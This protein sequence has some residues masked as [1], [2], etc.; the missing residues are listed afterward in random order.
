MAFSIFTAAILLFQYDREK[1]YRAGQ[2]EITLDNITTF[3][4]HFIEQNE[5]ITRNQINKIDSI[6]SL[7]PITNERL[8]VIDNTGVVLYDSEVENVAAMENHLQ[9][10]EV[11]KSLYSGIGRS[12]RKS[13]T[14]KQTYYYYSKNYDDYYI[15]TAVIYDLAIKDFLETEHLF[16]IVIMVLFVIM[17]IVMQ[18]VTNR[19]VNFISQLRDFAVSAAIGE[20]IEKLPELP[21][22]E[23]DVIGKK[24]VSIYNSLNKAKYDLEVEK[25]KL[26]EHLHVLAEGIAFFSKKNELKLNNGLYVQYLNLISRQPTISLPNIANIESLKPLLEFVRENQQTNL[27]NVSELPTYTTKIAAGE[28]YFQVKAI[29]FADKSYEILISDITRL[30]KRR[31]IKQQLTSN[32]AHELKTPVTSMKGYLETMLHAKDMPAEKQ[33]HFI[34]RAYFQSERLTE[35]LNDISLLNNIEDAGDLF[36]FKAVNIRRIIN[37]VLEN[38]EIQLKEKNVEYKV[39]V[40]DSLKVTANGSLLSS[41]FQNLVENTLKYAGDNAQMIIRHYHTDEKKY[42]FSFINTGPKI[43]EEH[44]GRIFERFYRIDEGRTR[45]NGGT[46]LGLSIV[47]NAILLHKGEITVRNRPEGGVEFL[48]SLP[49]VES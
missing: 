38:L 46:G 3:T 39:D 29:V 7:L 26:F 4:H 48:F 35:L 40:L 25:K 37:E 11:Q 42:Y 24:I 41:V 15:R 33:R 8:T 6:I 27:Y 12:I 10:P 45:Q 30:E 14:T 44:L 9:R 20:E 22:R 32:I 43:P 21:D 23:L 47:K 16:I 28:Y 31:L 19:I 36:E 17:W 18:Q 49:K 1:K 34:E 2:L 13:D 5:L